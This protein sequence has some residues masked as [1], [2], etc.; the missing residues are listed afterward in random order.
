M[1]KGPGPNWRFEKAQGEDDLADAEWLLCGDLD[2]GPFKTP[3]GRYGTGNRRGVSDYG[4]I[5]RGPHPVHPNRMVT[6]LAGPHSLG[7]GAA[8]LAATKSLLVRQIG[9]HL[10]GKVDLAD[11]ERTIWSLVRGVAADDLHIDPS[12]VTI[13]NAGVLV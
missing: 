6:V 1:Q 13:E 4:L 5:L 8:C 3:V 10:A 12:G 2:S 9:E 7:T 11:R